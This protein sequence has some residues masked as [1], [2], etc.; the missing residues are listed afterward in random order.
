MIV[1]RHITQS[2][3]PMVQTGADLGQI[4]IDG[5]RT[6][7]RREFCFYYNA[8][9]ARISFERGPRHSPA[10][11]RAHGGAL[12]S[13]YDA[14][15]WHCSSP[16]G[17]SRTVCATTI[18]RQV[19]AAA[20]PVPTPLWSTGCRLCVASRR[21]R[22][23]HDGDVRGRP[24][25]TAACW[26]SSPVANGAPSTLGC[27]PADRER[28]HPSSTCR[29]AA[30]LLRPEDAQLDQGRCSFVDPTYLSGLEAHI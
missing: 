26:G 10:A 6:G 12:I 18:A 21:R 25:D 14:A 30:R 16:P 17:A 20:E 8:D 2:R 19:L 5:Y 9:A 7:G 3:A 24:R 29:S 22:Y 4:P 11:S 28:A 23:E 15:T 13:F 27:L 1:G